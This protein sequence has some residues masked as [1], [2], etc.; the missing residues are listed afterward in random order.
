MWSR[1]GN[2]YRFAAL[3]AVT[4]GQL[5]A[6]WRNGQHL[7]PVTV[8]VRVDI[9]DKMVAGVS[10]KALIGWT[11]T[12][13]LHPI[14]GGRAVRINHFA[15]HYITHEGNGQLRY[16]RLNWLSSR[17]IE[18]FPRLALLAVGDDGNN[19]AAFLQRQIERPVFIVIGIGG[20]DFDAINQYFHFCTRQSIA[21]YDR[22]GIAGRCSLINH[23]PCIADFVVINFLN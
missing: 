1:N 7:A 18:H 17:L 8:H 10:H 5:M 2:H 12:A 23:F 15:A 9:T 20:S 14:T 11:R 13:Q 3:G 16:Y 21:A 19:V 22:V 4:H 6:A